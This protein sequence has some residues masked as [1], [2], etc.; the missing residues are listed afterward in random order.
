[1]SA[2]HAGCCQCGKVQNGTKLASK[3]EPP[4]NHKLNCCLAANTMAEDKK[5]VFD[6]TKKCSK[7]PPRVFPRGRTTLDKDRPV[8]RD[9]A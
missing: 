3:S 2:F 4:T 1:M 7:P 9:G 5:T 6:Y 8:Q